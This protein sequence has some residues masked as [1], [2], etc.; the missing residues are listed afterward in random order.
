M[1]FGKFLHHLK[2]PSPISLCL[3]RGHVSVNFDFESSA[4]TPIIFCSRPAKCEKSLFA[5]AK[6]ARTSD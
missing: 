3:L 5:A 6:P 4:V 2:G 1:H